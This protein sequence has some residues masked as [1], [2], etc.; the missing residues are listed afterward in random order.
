VKQQR[1]RPLS[2]SPLLSTPNRYLTNEGIE[3]LREYLCLPAEIVPATLKKSNRPTAPPRM[4]GDRPGGD[5]PR[6]DRPGG[7]FGGDRDGYRSG[8][9]GAGRGDKG[10]APGEFNPEFRGGGGR[11]GFGRGGGG[12]P[13]Y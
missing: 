5:R 10:G 8:P 4:G 13:S 6:G 2:C 3:Y 1:A 12:A 9:P 7:R 11:G